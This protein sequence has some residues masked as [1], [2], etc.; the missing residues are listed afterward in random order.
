MR[1]KVCDRLDDLESLIDNLRKASDEI[2]AITV[3]IGVIRGVSKGCKVKQLEYEAHETLAPETMQKIIEDLKS[4]YG[5]IDA[6]LEHRAGIV[7]VGE[8][9]MYA[10]VASKHREE[11]FKAL[12]ELV[13]RVKREAPIWKKE[14]T[15]KGA[16]WVEN[17]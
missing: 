2:G 4:K 10:A 9:V 5:I 17:I 7:K 3:F 13:D 1:A 11:G 15:E 8:D 14:L 6:F 16:Y 12:I